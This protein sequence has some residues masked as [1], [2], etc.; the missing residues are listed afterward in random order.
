M[1]F[2]GILR[3]NLDFQIFNPAAITA[4]GPS[5]EPSRALLRHKNILGK[6]KMS[7]IEKDEDWVD[8][9]SRSLKMIFEVILKAKV[10]FQTFKPAAITAEGLT[11]EP[12]RALLRHKNIHGKTKISK[13]EKDKDWVDESSR[14]LIIIFE[15]I[16]RA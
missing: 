4:E 16:S 15:V 11:S 12:S 3:A 1:E 10:D 13:I 9:S 8:K 2:Y 14:S 6:T 5:L 7:K